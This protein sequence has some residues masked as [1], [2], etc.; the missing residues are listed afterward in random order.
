VLKTKAGKLLKKQVYIVYDSGVGGLT[1]LTELIKQNIQANFVYVGDTKNAP[2]GNKT[3]EQIKKFVEVNIKLV[4]E[5]YIVKGIIMA[6]N[7]A[8]IL[9]KSYIERIFSIPVFSISESIIKH[10]NTKESVCFLTTQLTAKSQFFQSNIK[11]SIA[12]GCE[13]FVP[14]IESKMYLFEEYRKEVVRET[15]ASLNKDNY[16]N[17]ILA[18]THF[19]FLKNE[20]EEYVQNK[21]PVINPAEQ[22]IMDIKKDIEESYFYLEFIVTGDKEMFYHFVS[23]RL[24]WNIE[25]N[26]LEQ[27][28]I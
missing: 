23:E 1:V 16:Q 19:P 4:Q 12:I 9:A 5:K 22:F 3:P 28:A 6:C 10:I 26:I 13:R 21:I 14:M 7:T 27:E 17:I 20:I 2:Y 24:G 15:L 8:S 11:N 18:C 25:E